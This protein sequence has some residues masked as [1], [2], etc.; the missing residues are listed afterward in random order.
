MPLKIGVGIIEIIAII[1]C[2]GFF[3]TI[4]VR[5]EVGDMIAF[6]L[7]LIVVVLFAWVTLRS[8]SQAARKYGFLGYIAEMLL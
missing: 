1:E 7:K 2:I 4:W 5:S 8:E 6:I 3:I